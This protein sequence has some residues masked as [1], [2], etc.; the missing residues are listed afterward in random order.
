MNALRKL[1]LATLLLAFLGVSAF[2]NNSPNPSSKLRSKII[3][4]VQAPDMSKSDHNEVATL[5]FII[6]RDGEIVI[7]SVHTENRHLE[8][9]LKERLNYKKSGMNNYRPGKKYYMDLTFRNE[10]V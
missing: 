3:S 2:S 7:L 5:E 4:L 8:K 9:M 6:N 1:F 10:D